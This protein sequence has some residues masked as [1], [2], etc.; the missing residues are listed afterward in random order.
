MRFKDISQYHVTAY[1]CSQFN[2]EIFNR[3]IKDNNIIKYSNS[4]LY[5]YPVGVFYNPRLRKGYSHTRSHAHDRYF[6]SRPP[7]QDHVA[8][9]KDVHNNIYF[10]FQPYREVDVIRG[11]V[12]AWCNE[13]GL[14][15][16][17][18]NTTH[19]WYSTG[20]TSLIV[21]TLPNVKINYFKDEGAN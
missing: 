20:H 19:S 18:Y 3:F 4:W 21:I 6:T 9:L 15:A 11:E 2:M 13:Y 16:T 8:I 7:Y 12:D 14:K 10:T 17:Y 5:D 1:R